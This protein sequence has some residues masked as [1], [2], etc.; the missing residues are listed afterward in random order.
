MPPSQ[1]PTN[2]SGPYKGYISGCAGPGPGSPPP[3]CKAETTL[4]AA[5]RACSAMSLTEC[6]GITQAGG[7]AGVFQLRQLSLAISANPGSDEVSWA[8]N[9]SAEPSN[10]PADAGGHRYVLTARGVTHC[11]LC[12]KDARHLRFE[13]LDAGFSRGTPVSSI[14]GSHIQFVRVNVR[15]TGGAGIVL[16]G[17]DGLLQNST[18]R[19][20]ACKAIVVS[21]GSL[22]TLAPSGNRVEGNLIQNFARVHRCGNPSTL[23]L[24]V[25]LA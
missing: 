5:E 9:C 8:R 10:C 20:T 16:D 24:L 12:L 23:R 14:N 3:P 11:V 2:W 22:A 4:E 6:G 15:A 13:D 25:A 1:L 19:G 18:V 21:G 17:S 7:S